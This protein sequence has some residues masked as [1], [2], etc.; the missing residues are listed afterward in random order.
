LALSGEHTRKRGRACYKD[1]VRRQGPDKDRGSGAARALATLATL[2]TVATVATTAARA[3][4]GP[5]LADDASR[6]RLTAALG[7]GASLDAAGLSRTRAV[8][9]FFATGGVGA[10]WPVGAELAAFA[11]S[12]EG[13]FDGTPIDRLALAAVAVVR[14]AAWK[15]AL[16]DRRIR[17]RLLRAAAVEVGL[18]L[19]RDGTTTHAGSRFGLHLGARL[20][21]PLGLPGYASE[22]R[23]RL[24]VRRMEGFYT[25]VV[26]GVGVGN[27]V[28]LFSALVTVF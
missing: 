22:L 24:A 10:D 21:I 27:S 13:R 11:S 1:G 25:P 17:A 9:A 28:E 2:A 5:R 15:I 7:M 23:V 19:E 3:Q 8:P 4:D 26:Q 12:A 6:P 16:D 20:E 14:P 18:G